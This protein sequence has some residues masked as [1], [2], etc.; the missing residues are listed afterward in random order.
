[1]TFRSSGEKG[2]GNVL[3]TL[4]VRRCR[5]LLSKSVARP[6]FPFPPS[7]AFCFPEIRS[8]TGKLNVKINIYFLR[9]SYKQAKQAAKD[10]FETMLKIPLKRCKGRTGLH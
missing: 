5:L 7:R 8:N 1:M 2:K 9:S 6:S 4:T 3:R 10:T